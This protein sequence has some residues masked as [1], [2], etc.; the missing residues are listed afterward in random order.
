M[1]REVFPFAKIHLTLFIISNFRN[2]LIRGISILC[3]LLEQQE[4][5]LKD[6]SDPLEEL[7]KNRFL[8]TPLL[9]IIWYSPKLLST[10]SSNPQHIQIHLTLKLGLLKI[11][12]HQ[13]CLHLL[14]VRAITNVFL[15]N[16]N[17]RKTRFLLKLP[18][19]KIMLKCNRKLLKSFYF[20]ILRNFKMLWQKVNKLSM[21]DASKINLLNNNKTLLAFP[22]LKVLIQVLQMDR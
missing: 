12:T 15:A 14:E 17:K 18:L 10:S 3:F 11:K 4:E 5:I 16:L 22:L 1:E 13:C 8:A 2:P 6:Q 9:I 19:N 7:K 20:P 21:P